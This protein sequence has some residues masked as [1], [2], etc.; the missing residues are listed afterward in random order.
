[1]GQDVGFVDGAARSSR[2][3]WSAPSMRSTVS[4]WRVGDGLVVADVLGRPPAAAPGRSWYRAAGTGSAVAVGLGE[5]RFAVYGG[6][7]TVR[8]PGGDALPCTG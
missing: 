5:V 8:Y 1:M 7:R 4:W 2:T 6:H 3:L